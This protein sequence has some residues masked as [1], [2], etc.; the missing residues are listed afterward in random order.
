M[1]PPHRQPPES[2]LLQIVFVS[3]S[4]WQLSEAE[5]ARLANAARRANAALG[6]TG[7]LLYRAGRFYGV[8]EGLGAPLLAL[9]ERIMCDR[10]HR[11][12]RV[13]R[14]EEIVTR[15]FETWSFGSP[16]RPSD[17][18]DPADGAIEFILRLSQGAS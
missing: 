7:L 12:L 8:V 18:D 11:D 4:R 5:V 6:I 16:A 17:A 14:E 9:M 1:T 2:A 15:R 13:L 3:A 10:R